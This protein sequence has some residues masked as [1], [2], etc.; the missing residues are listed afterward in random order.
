MPPRPDAMAVTPFTNSVNILLDDVDK[1]LLVLLD[2]QPEDEKRMAK[3]YFSSTLAS[4]DFER[5]LGSRGCKTVVFTFSPLLL[6]SIRQKVRCF[7]YG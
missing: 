5:I 3:V 7:T 2:Q 4:V 6:T 1:E